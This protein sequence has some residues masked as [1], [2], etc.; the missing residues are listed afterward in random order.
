LSI[1]RARRAQ[2]EIYHDRILSEYELVEW[3]ARGDL[4]AR[5]RI[6]S[7]REQAEIQDPILSYFLM[8]DWRSIFMWRAAPGRRRS[9]ITSLNHGVAGTPFPE[10]HD[11]RDLA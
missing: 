11:E 2:E 5:T 3:R 8:E 6:R 10:E 9:I 1:I 7:E 4:R